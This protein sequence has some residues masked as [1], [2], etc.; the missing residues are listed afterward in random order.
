MN[1]F[2]HEH[3]P[4]QYGVRER[5]EMV[6]PARAYDVPVAPRCASCGY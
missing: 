5:V 2:R 4:A 3:I 1:I 6:A